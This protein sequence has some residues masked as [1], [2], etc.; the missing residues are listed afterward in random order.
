MGRL[1]RELEPHE[2]FTLW[3]FVGILDPTMKAFLS[4]IVLIC[5]ASISHAAKEGLLDDFEKAK[6]QAKAE[7]KEGFSHMIDLISKYH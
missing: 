4:T 6:T 5:L 7:N 3:R 2:G 1:P